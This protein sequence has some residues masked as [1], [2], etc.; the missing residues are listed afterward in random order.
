MGNT[1]GQ[2]SGYAVVL[3]STVYVQRIEPV[4]QISLEYTHIMLLSPS[5]IYPHHQMLKLQH[6]HSD[7][8]HKQLGQL[9]YRK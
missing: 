6:F 1:D 2:T 9:N 7:A 4:L 5:W 3:Q 8:L